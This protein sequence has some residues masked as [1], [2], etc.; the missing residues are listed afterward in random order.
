YNVVPLESID[1]V[2]AF[3]SG[4]PAEL[5]G[6]GVLSLSTKAGGT[7]YHGA[8]YGLLRNTDF[9]AWTF[10]AKCGTPG[11]PLAAAYTGCGNTAKAI[12]GGALTTVAGSKPGEHQDE[13]GITGG[14]PVKF[15][16]VAAGNEK[17]FFYASYTRFRQTV[18]VNPT[19]VT[20]PTTLMQQG[21]F[22][23][24]LAGNNTSGV[25]YPIYDPTTQAT[26]TAH[27]TGGAPCRY[28]YGYGPGSGIGANGNPVLTGTPN[29]IPA[30][31]ISPEM[32]YWSSFLPTP[33]NNTTGVI[34]NN[35]LG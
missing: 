14:G 13:Y 6:A 16:H 30:G 15:P 20:I 17:L 11:Q 32:K 23:E 4:Y 21:N 9:D 35:Y 5:Q 34:V 22:S 1:Q 12:I 26:C 2:Q 18:G 29:V 28:Q 10:S 19:A 8:I 31:E 33:T 25:N 7:K 27:N 3:T 24:L